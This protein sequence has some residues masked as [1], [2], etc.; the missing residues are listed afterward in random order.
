MVSN[1]RTRCAV[2]GLASL[3]T[4]VA[5]AQPANDECSGATEL[6]FAT[7]PGCVWYYLDNSAA[8]ISTTQLA[9]DPS[10]NG[11]RDIWF[12]FNSLNNGT[13]FAYLSPSTAT[14]W[15]LAVFDACGGTLVGC[16]LAP[17]TGVGIPV[18]PNTDYY[19]AISS[20]LDYGVAG[21]MSLCMYASN[22]TPP[23]A[24]NN[25]CTQGTLT[26]NS[27][28][29]P[30]AGTFLGSNTLTS[31]Y[32]LATSDCD[33]FY[34]ATATSSVMTITVDPSPLLD[35]A[36]E[37]SLGE[38]HSNTPQCVNDHGLGENETYTLTGLSIGE[39]V[40][41]RLLTVGFGAPLSPEYGICA[42]SP[43]QPAN[44]YCSGAIALPI[45]ASCQPLSGNAIGA[46]GWL[47]TSTCAGNNGTNDDLWYTVV[48]VSGD[49]ILTADGDGDA[50]TGYDPVLELLYANN[51]NGFNALDCV[52]STGP[53]A[54]ETLSYSGVIPGLTYYVRVYDNGDD[55]PGTTTFTV[56]AEDPT[57][58]GITDMNAAHTWTVSVDADAAR[59][60]LNYS[61]EATER[62]IIELLD[63]TGR[64][65]RT[66]STSLHEG[67][68]RMLAVGGIAPGQYIVALELNGTRSVQRVLLER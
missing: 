3:I 63:M 37:L 45:G 40:G 44:D 56:C 39:L 20:N 22:G 11:Y 25:S 41:I 14:D 55:V 49:I 47:P 4:S 31:P 19:M 26:V 17:T 65:L 21:T 61:G 32:C 66:W 42:W 16:A 7:D 58:T 53:G 30:V 67:D 27:S 54:A 38:C 52:N 8:T 35:V 33:V 2:L 9:C 18:T 12:Y 6:F 59:M 43:E 10:N 64:A 15:G 50:T 60:V 48:P 62:G 1:T 13:V 28:C 36:M 57:S 68:H 29:Q 5:M 46:T 34:Q 23:P 51:C 24:N